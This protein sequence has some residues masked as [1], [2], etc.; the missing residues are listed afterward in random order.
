MPRDNDIYFIMITRSYHIRCNYL[1]LMYS[2]RGI[3]DK[4]C[5]VLG[6]RERPIFIPPG[7]CAD[8]SGDKAS[9]NVFEKSPKLR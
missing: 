8:I 5:L 3:Q 7:E 2:K 6:K 9:D 1:Y 4:F